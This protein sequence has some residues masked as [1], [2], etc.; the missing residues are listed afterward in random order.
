MRRSYSN[1]YL[2]LNQDIVRSRFSSARVYYGNHDRARCCA[3]LWRAVIRE[4]GQAGQQV[5]DTSVPIKLHRK[6]T[7]VMLQMCNYNGAMKTISHNYN[8]QSHWITE[9]QCRDS[10]SDV[11]GMRSGD[12]VKLNETRTEKR[13]A[14]GSALNEADS[15]CASVGAVKLGICT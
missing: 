7:L 10:N 14:G 3:F 2:H 8:D 6:H 9:R 13:R 5:G 11:E 4:Q 1:V 12:R 15:L